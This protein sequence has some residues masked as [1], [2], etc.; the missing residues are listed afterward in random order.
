MH[1]R[2]SRQERIIRRQD[3]L[4]VATREG[5][6]TNVIS[7]YVIEYVIRR[8]YRRTCVSRRLRIRYSG[9]RKMIYPCR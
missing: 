4:E 3:R 2:I 5:D 8:H 9:Y 1:S 6:F 7:L